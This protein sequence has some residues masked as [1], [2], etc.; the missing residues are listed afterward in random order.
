MFNKY[1]A[2]ILPGDVGTLSIGACIASALIIGNFETA[3]VVVMIP[4]FLDFVI[5]I[6][7][8]FPK[9]LDFIKIKEGKLYSKKVVG[10]P[11]L[12]MSLTKCIS[13]TRLVM[14]LV[15]IQF[16][17]GVLAILLF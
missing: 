13:E 12:I 5:K 16:V 2:K 10:L 6:K 7:N 8:G 17:F 9:E 14:Y 15:S 4:Y 3:G 1:P 11:S